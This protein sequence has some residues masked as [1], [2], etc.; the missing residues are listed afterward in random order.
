MLTFAGCALLPLLPML[1]PQ[2]GAGSQE[3][4]AK[5]LLSRPILR[6]DGKTYRVRDVVEAQA[7]FDPTLP[8]FLDNAGYARLFFRSPLFLGQV[9]ALSDRLALDAAGIPSVP[10]EALEAEAMAWARD[11]Q[12]KA[13]PEA[14]LASHGLRIE[15][16]ARLIAIQPPE[17]GIIQLR[18]HFLSSV[19]EFYGEMQCSWIRI[20]LVDLETGA[21]L[22]AEE[23][24][25]RY[26]LLDEAARRIMDKTLTW[27]EAVAQYSQDPATRKR[28]GS[29]G[30]LRRTM[31]SRY[32]EPFLR[33]L[34]SGLGFKRP[35]GPLLKGPILG[36]AWVYLARIEAIQTRGFDLEQVIGRVERSLREKLLQEKLKEITKDTKRT[37]L[38]PLLTD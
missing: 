5:N 11:R 7:A 24:L 34:F 37:L 23:R 1:L 13:R 36:D 30:I 18:Q 19:P 31:T 25:R 32:E 35:D 10:R 12:S 17:F 14:V 6:Q 26:N 8:G 20:P 9:R 21:A 29:V 3:T 33:E 4:S 22:P 27:K 16:R 28:D 15:V 2:G 38:A